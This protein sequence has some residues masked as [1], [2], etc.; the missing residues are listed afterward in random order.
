MKSKLSVGLLFVFVL[1]FNLGCEK[2]D[3]TPSATDLPASPVPVTAEPQTPPAQPVAASAAQT[4]VPPVPTGETVQIGVLPKEPAA[5]PSTPIAAP[6]P[7]VLAPSAPVAGAAGG[8]QVLARGPVHNAWADPVVYNPEPSGVISQAPPA[9]IEEI[10]PTQRPD[11]A[12]WIPGY[13]AYD[14]EGRDYLWVSGTWRV[15]PPGRQWIPG[16]WARGS[17]GYQSVPGYWTDA[18]ATEVQYLPEPPDSVEA[19]PPAPP[20]PDVIYVPGVWMFS[21]STYVWRPGY[22]ARAEND[23]M[24]VP[25]H[26]VWAPRGYVF[27]DG[28]WD[29]TVPHRGILFAPVNVSPSVRVG[30]RFSPS[31]VIDI[32]LFSDN[33]FVGPRG[34]QYYFGDYYAASYHSAGYLPAFSMYTTRVGWDPIFAHNR[35]EHRTDREWEHGR[36]RMYE[37]RRDH[38]NAR[39]SRTT[40][41]IGGHSITIPLESVIREDVSR[42]KDIGKEDHKREMD[43]ANEVRR[44]SDLRQREESVQRP[45]GERMKLNRSPIADQ[46]SRAPERPKDPPPDKKVNPKPR[47]K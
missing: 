8:L 38:E 9:A 10:P 18:Q 31:M 28:Y 3:S 36:Q 16:Y 30:F 17:Q 27:V 5:L 21:G 26:Y 24:W 15:L 1:S 14:D 11:G 7:P 39:P 44:F 13:W 37:D 20:S 42:F 47:K 35:W 32:S 22:Y 33:L 23:F 25:A 12:E 29:Y 19:V 45:A 6:P 40:V 46:R 43:R 34:H 2:K 4:P 41:S